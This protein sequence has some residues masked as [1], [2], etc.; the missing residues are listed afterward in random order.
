MFRSAFITKNI[1][2]DLFCFSK[3]YTQYC[4]KKTLSYIKKKQGEIWKGSGD[5]TK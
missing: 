4:K 3:Q 5:S 1:Y 2:V